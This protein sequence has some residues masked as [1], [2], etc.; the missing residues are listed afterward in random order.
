MTKI[1][2]NTVNLSNKTKDLS[3]QIFRR[4]SQNQ[5]KYYISY[6]DTEKL[7]MKNKLPIIV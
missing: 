5:F 7:K 4:I 2:K 6:E 3:G 1:R